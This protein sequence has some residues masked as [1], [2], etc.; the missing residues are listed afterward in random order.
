MDNTCVDCY[1]VVIVLFGFVPAVMVSSIVACVLSDNLFIR[2]IL[3]VVFSLGLIF[4][5]LFCG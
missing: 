3:G 2:L 4:S 1:S 5:I